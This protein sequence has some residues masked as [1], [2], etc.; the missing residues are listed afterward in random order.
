MSQQLLRFSN[1]CTFVL[2]VLFFLRCRF[3]FLPFPTCPVVVLNV[4][5]PI[6]V[7]RSPHQH[8]CSLFPH[9]LPCI[10]S[11]RVPF[12]QSVARN[13][14][15]SLSV[16]G[17]V[18]VS[19]LPVSDHSLFLFRLPDPYLLIS[20]SLTDNLLANSAFRGNFSLLSAALPLSH[21]C[22]STL[23][24]SEP[25]QLIHSTAKDTFQCELLHWLNVIQLSKL[26]KQS[27]LG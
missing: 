20:T 6:P 21:A 4:F 9:Y 5:P 12:P 23:P 24:C 26:A 13:V 11:R 14:L 19:S 7:T 18:P 8:T 25:L 2:F 1:L 17:L 15:P 27:S 3:R 16:P 22:E 10:Y